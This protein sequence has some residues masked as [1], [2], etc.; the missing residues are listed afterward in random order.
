[1]YISTTGTTT[2]SLLA[3]FPLS[4]YLVRVISF[5]G[6]LASRQAR[7]VVLFAPNDHLG[8]HNRGDYELCAGVHCLGERGRGGT[9]RG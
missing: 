4:S 2:P 3:L 5:G 1:M 9:V 6:R 8:D 7:D